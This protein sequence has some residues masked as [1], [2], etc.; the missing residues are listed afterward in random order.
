MVAAGLEVGAIVE[1]D[2]ANVSRGERTS[3]RNPYPASRCH[4]MGQGSVLHAEP[5]PSSLVD[6]GQ[7]VYNTGLLVIILRPRLG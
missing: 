3:R 4:R 5:V 7:V 6:L 1:I 2:C